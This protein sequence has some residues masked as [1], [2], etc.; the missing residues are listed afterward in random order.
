[1]TT[2]FGR[3]FEYFPEERR[4]DATTGEV[5]SIMPETFGF[6][7]GTY[8]TEKSL[9]EILVN[10]ETGN[11]AQ[12]KALEQLEILTKYK[13]SALPRVIEVYTS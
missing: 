1:M 3:D 10:L 7:D 12:L 11:L 5:L 9:R 8:H 13:G 6:P 2:W 4:V